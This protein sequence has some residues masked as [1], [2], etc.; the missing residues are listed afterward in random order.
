LGTIFKLLKGGGVNVSARSDRLPEP[1]NISIAEIC[2]EQLKLEL[3]LH[4][5]YSSQELLAKFTAEN[6]KTARTAARLAIAKLL[7]GLDTTIED[8]ERQVREW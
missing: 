1:S 6:G 7:F 3:Y 2:A 4:R 8:A 5:N